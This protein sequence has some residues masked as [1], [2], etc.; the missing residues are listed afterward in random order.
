MSSGSR[1]RFTGGPHV[2]ASSFEVPGAERVTRTPHQQRPLPEVFRSAGWPCLDA[3]EIDLLTAG[4]LERVRRGDALEVVRVT[5]AGL[6][7][8][9]GHLERNRRAFDDHESLV[10][11]VA[12]VLCDAGR[13]VF[14]DLPLRAPVNGTWRSC[15]ADVY[16]IRPSTVS[17]YTS[18]VIHEIKVRRADLLADLARP[19]KRAAYQA[20]SAEFYYVLPDG[21]ARLEEIPVDS[22]VLFV[23][24]TGT[25]PGR[26][27]PRR[28]VRPG[29]AE[30]LSIARRGADRASAGESQLPLKD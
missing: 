18:P 3:I 8:L 10:D 28:A 29:L 5:E 20:V 6:A 14:R 27:S 25:R 13:L 23:G 24:P 21:L 1:P 19:E 30:W 26:P 11:T 12:R 16:S 9:A 17:A 4:L 7:A 15:R 2:R 22:G